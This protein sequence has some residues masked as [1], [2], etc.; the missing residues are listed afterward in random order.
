MTAT[1]TQRANSFRD[2]LQRQGKLKWIIAF[3]ASFGALLEVLD[4]SIVNVALTDMQSSFGAT[5]SQ[6]GWI[7]T[8]YAIANVIMIPLTAWLGDRFGKKRYF[9]FSLAG[10]TL[11]SM[12]CGVAP[13]LGLLITA[14]II[15]GLLGGGLLAKGQSILFETFPPAEQGL[16]QALFGVSMISGP[17]IGPTLGGYLTD[18]LGWRWIFFINLPVGILAVLM[19]LVFLHPDDH[20]QPVTVPK[21]D[22]WGIG[23]LAL[24]LGSFQV[25]LEEGESNSWFQ[26]PFIAWMAIAAAVGFVLFVWQELRIRHPAVDLRVLRYRS[27]AAG[28]IFS[29]VVGLGLYGTLFVIPIYAQRVLQYTAMQTGLLLLPGAIASAIT[30]LTMGRFTSKIDAR[31]MI[32]IGSVMTALVMFNLATLNPSTSADTLFLPLVVR[33]ASIVLMFLPLTLA[34][35]SPLP[36]RDIPAG[37]G[38]YN[39]TRQLGG[40]IGIAAL[41]TILDR[42]ETFHRAILSDGVSLYNSQTQQRLQALTAAM[43]SKGAD[44]T[45]AKQQAL[46]LL[47]QTVNLQATLLA[48]EDMF[49]IVGW[50]FLVTLPLVFLLGKGKS[51]PAPG[52]H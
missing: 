4:S 19:A 14:R 1:A 29:M 41:S 37:T 47:D 8:G 23:F 40:S 25:F 52:S 24:A 18:T 10:F 42:R 2:S 43:Q 48:Y 9:V 15:Q 49:R 44:P 20:T 16:A 33:G 31:L 27:L 36:K 35:I 28:S 51:K 7:V 26:S 17:A 32:S 39:L 11:A 45:T 30:M 13:N 21:V 6:I 22:W 34:T 12:A 46:A 5:L 38:F 3:T 50:V